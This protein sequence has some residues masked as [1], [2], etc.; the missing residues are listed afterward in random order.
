MGH[1]CENIEDFYRKRAVGAFGTG[2]KVTATDIKLYM[3]V[4]GRRSA[5]AHD[6]G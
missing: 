4:T 1:L 6:A 2:N 5:D 3:I